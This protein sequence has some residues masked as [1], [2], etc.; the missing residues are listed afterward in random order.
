MKLAEMEA[1]HASLQGPDDPPSNP[2][3]APPLV[4]GAGDLPPWEQLYAANFDFLWRSLRRLGV[5]EASLDDATQDVF[6]VAV[7]RLHEFEGRSAFRTWLFGIA[8]HVARRHRQRAASVVMAGGE[9][10][11]RATDPVAVDPQAA[12]ARSEAMRLVYRILHAMTAEKR[13]TFVMAELEQIPIPEIAEIMGIPLNTAY[14][15]LRAARR[16]FEEGVRR[17][18]ARD[19][20]RRHG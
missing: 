6:L 14:S 11:E 7:R 8:Y 9:T 2:E 4:S 18:R 16:E 10:L 19:T 20:W 5:A 12:A 15:R 3:P 17:A 1:T 13:D